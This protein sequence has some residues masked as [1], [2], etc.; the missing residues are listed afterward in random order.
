M[1]DRG[2]IPDEILLNRIYL[3][4]EQK[5]MLDKGLAD[6]YDVKAIRLRE[7][8]KR[9]PDR[10]PANFMFQLTFEEAL[11]MVSQNAIPSKQQLG[12]TLPY[13]ITEHGILM[14]S[15][16]LRSEGAIAMSICIIELF[17]KLREMMVLHK[18]VSLLFGTGRK[19]TG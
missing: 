8:V 7:Q 5:V 11:N 19:E 13:A 12:G 1:A 10:F 16:V 18:N 2:N 17:V 3:I 15:N 14:L 9:N 4:R 6:L